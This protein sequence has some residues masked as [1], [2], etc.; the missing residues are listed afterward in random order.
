[1][2]EE[3]S[4]QDQAIEFYIQHNRDQTTFE[5]VIASDLPM[6]SIDVEEALEMFL[7]QI[8][9]NKTDVF[10]MGEDFIINYY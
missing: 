10:S 8:R 9:F 2:E 3:T 1:M 4:V 6:E 5:L 7:N